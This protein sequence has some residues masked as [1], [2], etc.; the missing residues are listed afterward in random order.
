MRRVVWPLPAWPSANRNS[1]SRG[2]SNLMISSV[3]LPVS[4]PWRQTGCQLC[5]H[6]RLRG[7]GGGGIP[8]SRACQL[9]LP[10]TVVV[11]KEVLRTG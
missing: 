2:R 11:V 4:D 6:P 1:R 5:C 7:G 9:V 8:R 10:A 3:S